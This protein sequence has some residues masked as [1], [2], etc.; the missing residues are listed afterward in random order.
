[1]YGVL[2]NA[3]TIQYATDVVNGTNTWH[4]LTNLNLPYVPYEFVDWP[5]TNLQQRFY[6]IYQ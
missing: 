2:G 1:L 4:F 3:T 5:A 6:R